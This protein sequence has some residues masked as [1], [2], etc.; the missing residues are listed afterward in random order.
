MIRTLWRLEL[1]R[2]WRSRP[3]V[4]AL[5]AWV[6]AAAGATL[7][8]E[9]AIARQ[10][11]ALAASEALQAEQHAAVLSHQSGDANAGDQLYYLAFHTRHEPSSWAALSLGQ[12][13]TRAFNL[14]IRMLALHGQLYDGD[15][16]SPVL[17]ALGHVD[18]V[19][20]LIV[21]TPLLVIAVAHDVVS[22]EHEAGTWPLLG[23]QPVAPAVVLAV[24]LAVRV[25]AVMLVVAAATLAAPLMAGAALDA[26]VALAVLAAVIYVG[27]W[28]LAAFAVNT[29]GRGSDVNALALLGLWLAW[30]V[31]GPTLVATAA[32]ARFPAPETLELTVQ[33]R[34]GYHGAWDR[35]VAETMAAFY[36]RYPEWAATP[37]RP[38]AIRMLVARHAAAGRRGRPR[39]RGRGR[40]DTAR[41]R[42]LGADLV[43]GVPA[44]TPAVGVRPPGTHRSAGAPGVSR[45]GG[46]LP[47][48]SEAPFLPGGV[49]R[50][51]DSRRGL[52][53]DAAAPARR[54]RRRGGPDPGAVRRRGLDGARRRPRPGA[55][56]PPAAGGVGSSTIHW[57]KSTIHARTRGIRPIARYAG[58]VPEAPR[59]ST[60]RISHHRLG[61]PRRVRRR[62]PAGLRPDRLA[63]GEGHPRGR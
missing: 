30:V 20:V 21:L 18:F 29:L 42:R 55:A 52:V 45:F 10:A 47:R 9:R 58:E 38:T 48:A 41:A 14:K 8:G 7:H 5:L 6:V 61:P 44:G 37:C 54:R 60:Y 32:S 24:K 36:R 57:S 13:E 53:G 35:P 3:L 31:V 19:F 16:T 28:G 50:G 34:Q 22:G 12:R 51:A 23:A 63:L 25:G 46:R 49:L 15:L 62:H 56:P 43:V 27:L 26:R 1:A 39:G 59:G 17:D 11:A 33:Q 2:L 40:R 4:I